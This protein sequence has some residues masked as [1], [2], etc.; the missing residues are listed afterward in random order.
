MLL[1]RES[2]DALL[3][4]PETPAELQRRFRTVLAVRNYARDVG[5]EVGGQY[6]SYVAWPGDRVITTIVAA[7]PGEVEARGFRFPLVGRLPYKG[8]FD[9]EAAEAEAETLRDDGL[10]V[11]VVP[12]RAYSTLGW[13]DDPLTE[14]ML[15][16]DDLELSETI[17]HELV[18]AT[19]HLASAADFN[20]GIATFLGQE[21]AAAFL[22][23]RGLPDDPRSPTEL[24][25]RQRTRTS[26]SRALAAEMLR[27]QS[28][29]AELYASEQSEPGTRATQRA[30]LESETRSRVAAKDFTVYNP[31]DL[32][33]TLRLND[34]CLAL[35]GTYAEDL[36]AH[37]RVFETL[38]RDLP[39]FIAHLRDSAAAA[40][41]DTE[42]ELRRAFFSVLP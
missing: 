10:D 2:I 34:A 28:E 5:L 25:A 40:T 17:L 42:E 33:Q 39:R 9:L 1:A 14:P 35:R 36:E 11:C 41:S 31:L 8:Y 37:G 23:E 16:G 38:G 26:E 29:V 18:H 3:S 4:N 12:V 13:I 6:T 30:L 27:F 19:V 32:A 24:A 21:A 15:G 20:E 22:A 7:R